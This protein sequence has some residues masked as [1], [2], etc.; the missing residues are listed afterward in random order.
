[1]NTKKVIL[2]NIIFIFISLFGKKKLRHRVQEAS[3]YKITYI[4]SW[5]FHPAA[6]NS[7]CSA[8]Q[9]LQICITW[10]T[11]ERANT[12]SWPSVTRREPKLNRAAARAPI[13]TQSEC[14]LR[15]VLSLRT[16]L[17]LHRTAYISY[18]HIKLN[19]RVHVCVTGIERR[20]GAH[21]LVSWWS[22]RRHILPVVRPAVRSAARAARR[23][24]CHARWKGASCC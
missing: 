18:I 2:T 15:R 9:S 16:Y 7:I 6:A 24:S 23:G 8:G 10:G 17:R 4:V 21:Y 3:M 1:M 13:C 20:R 5:I 22:R 11:S 14:V 12:N 19:V